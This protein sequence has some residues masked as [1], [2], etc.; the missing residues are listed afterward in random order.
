MSNE[1]SK[2]DH[3][4]EIDKSLDELGQLLDLAEQVSKD[5]DMA[6]SNAFRKIEYLFIIMIGT[7]F[8]VLVIGY[9][10]TNVFNLNS[11]SE[12]FSLI[13]GLAGGASF[14]YLAVLVSILINQKKWSVEQRIV[15]EIL[16]M[17]SS[18][19]DTLQGEIGSIEYTLFRMRMRRLGLSANFS[20]LGIRFG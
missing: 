14:V 6:R 20:F 10:Q 19:L 7:F 2:R 4:E 5:L 12:F 17:A 8:S 3:T 18:I 16:V 1:F 11:N 15:S 13:V 9:S